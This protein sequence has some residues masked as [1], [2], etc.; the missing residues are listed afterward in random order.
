LVDEYMKNAMPVVAICAVAR[1]RFKEPVRKEHVTELVRER[2]FELR[3]L[4]DSRKILSQ[5]RNQ[6]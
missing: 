4:Q 5:W 3:P 2:G 1:T 6:K